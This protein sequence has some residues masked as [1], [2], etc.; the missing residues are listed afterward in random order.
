[1]TETGPPRA[2]P[3]LAARMR[4]YFDRLWPLLRSLT[5]PGV[6]QTHDILGEL[7]PL[8]RIEI[9]SGTACF[10]WIVPPE[11]RLHEAHITGP[12][13][14]TVLDV[15]DHNLHVVNYSTGFRG[16]LSRAEL[17]RHLH[18][19]PDRPD[20]IP[21]V[22]SYYARTWGF[23]LPHSQ[24][25]RLPEGDYDVVLNAE[26]L[27]GSMTLSEA[28]LPGSSDREV[29]ISSYTCHPSMANNELS[30]PLA[31]AFLYERLRALPERRL[32]YR[33][34]LIP[35]TIGSIAYLAR[36]G[37]ALS[38]RVVAGYVLTCIGDAAG[39]TYKR[40]RQGTSAADRAAEAT[41]AHAAPDD[42]AVM[43][44]RPDQG[45]DERQYC[46]PGFDLPIGCVMRSVPGA[47]PEYH[48]SDDNRDLLAF[49]RLAESVELLT[50]ICRTLEINRT[51]VSTK[52]YGEPHLGRYGLYPTTSKAEAY[53]AADRAA[54]MWVLNLAD[55]RH[56]LLE[57]A[58]RSGHAPERLHRMAQAA[59][60]AGLLRE[61]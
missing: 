44:F 48:T 30:G 22:T 27:D 57:M 16:R 50:E 23:C 18:S 31:L 29:L 14:T 53:R 56:D 15:R 37:R 34:V 7:L 12:D 55:G 41:L 43:D 40:S 45:S 59:L 33:F 3:A 6:R 39:I 9:P 11:W 8:M 5:G 36:S 28:V 17:D 58:A 47:Y 49:D 38:E 60:G 32:T 54:L 51:Y 19:R 20:A 26:H 35:E 13:G 42:H 21:Y 46:S 2:N 1:M 10:D 52:P 4:A 61:A 24:R 25:T